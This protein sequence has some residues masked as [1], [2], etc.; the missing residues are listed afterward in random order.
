[1]KRQFFRPTII[2]NK[3][4][5]IPKGQSKSRETSNTGYTGR[6]KA[7]QTTHIY[8]QTNTNNVNKTRAL[9]HTTAGKD[10]PNITRRNQERKD[11]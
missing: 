8:A 3:R 7:N 1:M 11:G 4:Q 6:R 10:D 5:R 2:S 9:Q